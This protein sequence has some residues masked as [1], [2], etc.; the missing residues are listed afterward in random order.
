MKSRS[1][2]FFFKDGRS[3]T[4]LMLIGVIRR[5]RTLAYKMLF[6]KSD[7]RVWVSVHEGALASAGAGTVASG[8]ALYLQTWGGGRYDARSLGEFSCDFFCF[9]QETGH[10]IIS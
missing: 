9:L 7:E 4:F 1:D 3:Y 2:F 5:E 10:K 6:I 8:I